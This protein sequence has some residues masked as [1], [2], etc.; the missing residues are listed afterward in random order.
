MKLEDLK[1]VD[2]N[3]NLDKYIEYRE[4]TKSNMQYPEWL[5]DFTKEDLKELLDNGTKIWLII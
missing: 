5:G 2:N 3:I 1:C 4:Y